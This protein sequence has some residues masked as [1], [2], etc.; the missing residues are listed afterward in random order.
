MK[1]QSFKFS[2]IPVFKIICG[3]YC[4]VMTIIMIS[5]LV[6]WLRLRAAA[7]A[8]IGELDDYDWEGVIGGTMA[9]NYPGGALQKQ[10]AT[11]MCLDDDY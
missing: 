11:S 1:K 3:S 8:I 7:K 9:F 6:W 10:T 4:L 2:D 5:I